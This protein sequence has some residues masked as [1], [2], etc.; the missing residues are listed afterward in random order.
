MIGIE[1][2][3][4]SDDLTVEMTQAGKAL[5]QAGTQSIDEKG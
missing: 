1:Q 3:M 5:V 4:E 2:F